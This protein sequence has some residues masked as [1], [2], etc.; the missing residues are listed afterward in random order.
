MGELRVLRALFKQDKGIDLSTCLYHNDTIHVRL[1]C[2]QKIDRDSRGKE[3]PSGIVKWFV[4]VFDQEDEL[5]AI[6]TILTMVQKKN[7][8]K[9]I[10]KKSVQNYLSKLT[11]DS[12]PLWGTM[13]PQQMV[14]HLEY[15]L[16]V[17]SGEVQDFEIETPEKYLEKVQDSLNTHDKIPRN[18]DAPKL[19]QKLISESRYENLAEA[20]QKL[21]EAYDAYELHF[22]ENPEATTKNVVFGD[23]DK[24]EWSLMNTKHFNHHFEQF[25]LL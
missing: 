8:F 21:V 25:N 5:V 3:L 2:K 6:A 10:D 23:L 13:S 19:L 11:E 22:K 7:P 9:T 20:K 18:F 24:F 1:T 17:A 4:E 14:E 12:K 16:R 15:S